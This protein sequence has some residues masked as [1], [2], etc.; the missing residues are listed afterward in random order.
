LKIALKN[1]VYSVIASPISV[2]KKFPGN[3]GEGIR[4]DAEV[5]NKKK[6]I[7]ITAPLIAISSF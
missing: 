7:S 3:I 1:S 2:Q 4:S 5:N 6:A